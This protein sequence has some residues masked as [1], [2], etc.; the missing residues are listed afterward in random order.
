MAPHTSEAPAC[1]KLARR[2]LS[3]SSASWPA[4]APS[5]PQSHQQLA[6]EICPAHAAWRRASWRGHFQEQDLWQGQKEMHQDASL[7][8]LAWPGESIRPKEQT[9][10]A[11]MTKTMRCCRGRVLSDHLEALSGSVFVML[12]SKSLLVQCTTLI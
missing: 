9:A 12:E 10:S 5:N 4:A 1:A 2:C 8:T 6:N 11:E 7:A 3:W